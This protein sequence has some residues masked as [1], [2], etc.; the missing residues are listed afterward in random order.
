[1]NLRL[2]KTEDIAG[3]AKSNRR[4]TRRR[5]AAGRKKSK[6]P[7][8]EETS[9]D[10]DNDDEKS[11]EGNDEDDNPELVPKGEDATREPRLSSME[12]ELREMEDEQVR[13]TNAYPGATNTIGSVHQRKWYLSLDRAG[14][15]FVEKKRRVWQQP[16]GSKHPQSHPGKSGDSTA[17]SEESCRLS[18]PFYVRGSDHERSVVTG[19]RGTDILRDENVHDFT[20]RKGWKPVVN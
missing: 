20:Q 14:C 6:A 12:R 19:R 1:M 11:E 13:R 18:Y 8:P 5:T 16:V 15:G 10:D 4:P 3:R 9:N 7:D 2:T 17:A